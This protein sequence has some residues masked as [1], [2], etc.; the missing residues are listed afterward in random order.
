MREGNDILPG[1][2][3]C[4]TGGTL[5]PVDCPVFLTLLPAAC[6]T[7]FMTAVYFMK[8]FSR[9]SSHFRYAMFIFM[10]VGVDVW[11]E[12]P[13]HPN[14]PAFST[15]CHCRLLQHHP[16]NV[17]CYSKADANLFSANSVF[18]FFQILIEFTQLHL[19]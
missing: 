18:N 11:S 6:V 16:F 1:Y 10:F 3:R 12:Y 8:S 9:I 14:L 19:L 17:V 13:I 2:I 7:Y 4:H 15:W 5:V